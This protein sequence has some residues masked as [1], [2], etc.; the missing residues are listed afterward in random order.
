MFSETGNILIS[1]T[2]YFNDIWKCNFKYRYFRS[3][4]HIIRPEKIKV[5]I[6]AFIAEKNRVGMEQIRLTI[7][8]W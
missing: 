6:S 3:G 5:G 4:C 2:I 1:A 7:F 8:V